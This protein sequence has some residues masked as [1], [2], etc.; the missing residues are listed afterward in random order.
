MVNVFGSFYEGFQKREDEWRRQRVDNARAYNQF[1]SQN[2]Y[3]SY[4]EY[5]SFIDSLT[6]GDNYLRGGLPGNE[7][8]QAITAEGQKM[9]QQQMMMQQMD[10]LNKQAQTEGNIAALI[11]RNALQYDDDQ[12]LEEAV[13]GQLGGDANGARELLKRYYPN[14]YSAIREQSRASLYNQ[15]LPKAIEFLEKNPNAELP[16]ELFPGVAPNLFSSFAGIAKSQAERKYRETQ[17]KIYG[18]TLNTGIRAMKEGV[19][20]TPPSALS[21]EYLD[22][23]KRDMEGARK[24]YE[25][26]RGDLKKKERQTK[27]AQLR[28]SL[29]QDRDGVK[30]LLLDPRVD[31]ERVRVEITKRLPAFGLED[32]TREEM[33]AIIG[34]LVT[35]AQ[36]TQR[37]AYERTN[38]QLAQQADAAADEAQ[39]KNE[40]GTKVTFASEA[41]KPRMGDELS[42]EVASEAIKLLGQ[43]YDIDGEATAALNK[44]IS[45]PKVQKSIKDAKGNVQI[46]QQ[47]IMAH[48][49][50]QATMQTR[51]RS[52]TRQRYREEFNSTNGLPQRQP[53]PQF[54]SNFN[55]DTTTK[56]DKWL[57]NLQKGMASSAPPEAKI[58][59]LEA[60][61]REMGVEARMADMGLNRAMATANVWAIPG[62]G[63]MSEEEVA[64]ARADRMKA[65]QEVLNSVDTALSQLKQLQRNAPGAPG[66]PPRGSLEGSP[67]MDGT[68]PPRRVGPPISLGEQ[69]FDSVP[70]WDWQNSPAKQLLDSFRNP[71]RSPVVPRGSLEGSPGMDGQ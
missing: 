30:Q 43:T 4:A 49:D 46:A 42:A 31:N 8:L 26:E 38:A 36:G 19:D 32:V 28:M 44:A 23:Y 48:P 9:K 55:R 10:L 17:E 15:F 21:G 71:G 56:R 5:Q 3:A 16:K 60:I 59:A 69:N 33:D 47:A 27:V 12:K 45:D 7:V 35:D 34:E 18:D 67:G 66:G 39:K 52:M 70:G 6:G 24:K 29:N 20:F 37:N 11:G 13:A 22:R 63:M 57:G 53:A 50:V 64:A 65:I 54:L 41:L 62:Q 1:R 14:G 2:P 61:R 40:L 25:T 58:A 51:Q 68:V